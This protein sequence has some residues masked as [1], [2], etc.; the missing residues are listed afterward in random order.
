MKEIM[1]KSYT[2]LNMLFWCLIGT[3]ASQERK[4]MFILFMSHYNYFLFFHS[5]IQYILSEHLPC[6]LLCKYVMKIFFHWRMVTRCNH[7]GNKMEHELW[8][9]GPAGVAQLVKQH[10]VHQKVSYL[11]LVRTYTYL[12]LGF[13][14]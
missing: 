8:H 4:I 10:P 5:F 7:K 2:C 1:G 12:G 14:L 11:I 3:S 6:A 9:H 13:D